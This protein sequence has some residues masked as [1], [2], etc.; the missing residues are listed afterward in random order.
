MTKFR[1]RSGQRVLVLGSRGEERDVGVISGRRRK[2][3][4]GSFHMN[5]YDVKRD[6][7]TTE[8]F[9]EYVLKATGGGSRRAY[10]RRKKRY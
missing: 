3:V 8:T 2:R 1:L 5:L 10:G 7:G 6:N 9:P 4:V